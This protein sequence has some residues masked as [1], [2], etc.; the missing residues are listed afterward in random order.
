MGFPG[1]AIGK[2][3]SCQCGR[4]EM[5]VRSPGQ[6]DRLEEGMATHFNILAWSIPWTGEPGGLW[7]CKESDTTEATEH[8]H[9]HVNILLYI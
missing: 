6:E 9:V 1:G 7:G 5:W 2:E 3:P 8:E 4:H